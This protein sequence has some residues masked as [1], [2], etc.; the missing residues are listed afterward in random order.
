MATVTVHIEDITA[1]MA[2][3]TAQIEDATAHTAPSTAQIETVTVHTPHFEPTAT[4]HQKISKPFL[5]SLDV[6]LVGLLLRLLMR[7][8]GSRAGN[9]LRRIWMSNKH[10]VGVAVY[11]VTNILLIH[12]GG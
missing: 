9:I 7:P 4:A 10:I 2:P 11:A 1:H 8:K 12:F 5:F 6:S 3:L